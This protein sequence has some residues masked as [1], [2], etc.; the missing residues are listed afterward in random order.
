MATR[1]AVPVD[2]APA[3]AN[4]SAAANEGC[5]IKL[6]GGVALCSVL[7]ERADGVLS[8]T[9]A[10]G[11]MAAVFN[12]VG[13]IVRIRVGAVAVAIYVELTPDALAGAKT[14]VSTNIVFAKALEAGNPGELIRAAIVAAYI[15][16]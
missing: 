14:A 13:D 5:L 2:L 9:P 6:V 12:E 3:A 7:G 8:N 16:P 10:L 11:A 4:L 15:K 1:N